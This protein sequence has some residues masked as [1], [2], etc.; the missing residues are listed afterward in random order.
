MRSVFKILVGLSFL[1]ASHSFAGNTADAEGL[2]R[3]SLKDLSAKQTNEISFSYEIQRNKNKE[4]EALVPQ[5]LAKKFLQ[6]YPQAQ[7]LIV[8]DS[9]AAKA[10]FKKSRSSL[11]ETE[12]YHSL[13][14]VQQLLTSFSQTYPAIT[15]VVNYGSS[16]QGHD[17]MALRVGSHLKD[18]QKVSRVLLTA[19]THGDEIITTEV[20]L[21]LLKKVLVEASQKNPRFV[22]MLDEHEI[23]FVP[24]LNPDGFSKQNRYDNGVD[25]NRSYPYP[26]HPT[27]TPTSSIQAELKLIEQFPIDGSIDFHAF[28]GVI[29]YPWG[30]TNQSL[31]AEQKKIFDFVT[32]KMAATNG[33]EFGSIVDLM[34]IARGSSCD[35]YYWKKGTMAIA[36]ELGNDKSPDPSEF[37]KYIQEQDESTWIFIESFHDRHEDFIGD[38]HDNNKF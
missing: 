2:S 10:K 27:A 34:Y 1:W 29:I 22:K 28:S 35:Y 17:L 24:V 8:D 4:L 36:I 11:L 16:K 15:E 6:Q 31:P 33:Y 19:A 14:E 37:P 3:F 12:R 20:L 38:Q 9:A 18:S 26:D 5:A 7:L 23:M 32:S 30:Y 21:A 13:S 25:P